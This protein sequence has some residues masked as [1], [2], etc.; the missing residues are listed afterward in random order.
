MRADAPR[1]VA[2]SAELPPSELVDVVMR[3]SAYAFELAGRRLDQARENVKKVRALMRRVESRGYATLERLAAYF[4][5]LRAGDDSNAVVEAAGA[6]NL[7][8]FT[9]PRAWNFRSSSSSTSTCLAGGVPVA[10]RSSS[11][12]RTV[13]RSRV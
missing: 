6:V 3:E 11:A 10:C 4:D 2:R 1:W 8:T 5:T 12:G 13:N 7:M 9:R